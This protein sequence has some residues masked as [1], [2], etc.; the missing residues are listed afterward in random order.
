[1]LRIVISSIEAQH[2]VQAFSRLRRSN[3]IYSAKN[4][5]FGMKFSR[6]VGLSPYLGGV[7]LLAEGSVFAW[8]KNSL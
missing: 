2:L 8:L 7:C 1:M 3:E 6:H 4:E 5:D